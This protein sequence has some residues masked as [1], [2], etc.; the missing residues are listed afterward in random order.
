MAFTMNERCALLEPFGA[1]F[2]NSIEEC[3]VVLKS[4]EEGAEVGK[5]YEFLLMKMENDSRGG[6]LDKWLESS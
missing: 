5:R 4:F 2:Y 3:P 1:L 6:Y